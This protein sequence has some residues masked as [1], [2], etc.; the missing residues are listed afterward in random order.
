MKKFNQVIS[1][2]ISVDSI[3]ELLCNSLSADFKHKEIVAESIVGRMLHDGSLGYLYNS[4][5]GYPCEIDFK[6]GDE[7]SS[8]KYIS[9]YGY[10]ENGNK[11][12]KEINQG[13]VKKINPYSDKK[14]M[15]SYLVPNKAGE[16]I[17][18]S[19]WVKH[20]DWNKIAKFPMDVEAS[21]LI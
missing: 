11:S 14:L 5:N 17:E 12:Y 20:T 15:I 3:S 18:E 7:V 8:D 13:I 10:W 21:N 19:E 2:E 9:V 16:L 1:V 4:L 6:E